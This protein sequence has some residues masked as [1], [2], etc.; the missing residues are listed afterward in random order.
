MTT[1]AWFSPHSIKYTKAQ[2]RWL[3]P[4]LPLLGQ[5]VYPRSH[6]ETGYE[7]NPIGRKSRNTQAPF[8][9]AQEIHA[10]LTLRIQRAG[11][12]GLLLELLYTADP[13]DELFIIQHIARA[14][15]EDTGQTEKRIRNALY[16]C[17]G[18][19]RKT[20]SYSQYIYHEKGE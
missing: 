5:G 15:G 1:N 3:I 6:K 11:L 19:K 8:I 13:D 20:R 17:S 16:Y 9:K 2:I 7:D 18:S 12:D 10:E 14:L 4:Y